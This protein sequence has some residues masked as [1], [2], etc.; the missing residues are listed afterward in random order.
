MTTDTIDPTVPR[1]RAETGF[2]I[3]ENTTPLRLSGFFCLLLGLLSFV[4]LFGQPLLVVPLLAFF[5][6]AFALRR[7][8]GPRPIGVRPAM[9]GIV[10]AAAFGA[11][12]L[13]MPW[14]KT[15][16]LAS[17][18]KLY[19]RYYIE[20]V[21]RGEDHFAIEMKKDYVNRLPKTM[22]LQEHY[23]VNEAGSRNWQDFRAEGINESIRSRGLNA[24]WV[25][26]RPVRIYYSYGREHAELIWKDPTEEVKAKIH[27]IM[28]YMLDQEG[29]GQWHV[30]HCASYVERIT[31][32]AIL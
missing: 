14:F 31:A 2:E 6:G 4:S 27:I 32:P 7:F 19:S 24:E 23:A 9:I 10:L 17:Q 5:V 25:L 21:A 1:M 20:L 28:D 12:G 16:T 18:A 15:L 3:E 22:N 8:E 11:C 13:F 26:D 30:E 29:Q